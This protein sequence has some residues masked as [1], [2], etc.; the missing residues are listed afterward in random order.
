MKR[1]CWSLTWR[2]TDSCSL[3]M[4]ATA[5]PPMIVS[6]SRSFLPRTIGITAADHCAAHH[7]HHHRRRALLIIAD[8][9]NR[10]HHQSRP[11][12]GWRWLVGYQS[13]LLYLRSYRRSIAD[14]DD[15]SRPTAV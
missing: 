1:Q 3:S 4:S 12:A 13:T 2:T 14:G 5:I 8:K 15:E 10:L 7:R 9:V 6:R 11:A